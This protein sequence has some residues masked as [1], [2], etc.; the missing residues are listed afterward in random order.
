METILEKDN[1]SMKDS[2]F[3]KTNKTTESTTCEQC[4]YVSSQACS[5]KR[6]LKIHI[7]E[8]PN[9]CSLCNYATTQAGNLK[10]HLKIHGGEKAN[11]CNLCDYA[12]IKSSYLKKHLKRHIGQK[13]KQMLPM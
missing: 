11:K 2:L 8:K 6:H 3:E 7:G 12:S 13:S 5:F 9:K 1:L 10:A 4:D